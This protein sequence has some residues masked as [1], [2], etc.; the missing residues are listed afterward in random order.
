MCKKRLGTVDESGTPHPVDLGRVNR[1]VRPGTPQPAALLGNEDE[2]ASHATA[3][4]FALEV[5][6]SAERGFE[7][8]AKLR[9]SAVQAGINQPAIRRDTA[10]GRLTRGRI[11]GNTAA[12]SVVRLATVSQF[13]LSNR[14]LNFRCRP[15]PR[16]PV[17]R[18][19]LVLQV[20]ARGEALRSLGSDVAYVVRTIRQ[21][22]GF[23]LTVALT[24]GLGIGAAATIYGV[25]DRLL[26]RGP[27]HVVGAESLRRVYAHV[28]SKASGEFTTGTVSYSAYVAMRDRTRSIAAAAAYHQREYRVAE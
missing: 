16:H 14:T 25:I 22:P 17:E 9:H 7:L 27:D 11:F 19:K 2:D 15:E 24:L 6:V 21:S 26:L 28:R 4:E 12:G 23:A 10:A 13:T 1:R 20:F 5:V 8:I 18:D 3:R